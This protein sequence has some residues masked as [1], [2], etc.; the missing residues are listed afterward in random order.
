MFEVFNQ[1]CY[2]QNSQPILGRYTSIQNPG[3]VRNINMQVAF[4]K[5][6]L[7]VATLTEI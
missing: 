1:I 5:D 3:R 4:A 2:S 7:K 6:S